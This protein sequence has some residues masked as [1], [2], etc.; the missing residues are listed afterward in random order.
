MTTTPTTTPTP[1]STEAAQAE[2]EAF[3]GRVVTDF[4]GAASTLMTVLGDRLGL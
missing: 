4:A 1:S 2:T 3:L